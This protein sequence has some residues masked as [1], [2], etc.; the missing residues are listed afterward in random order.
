MAREQAPAQEG[1]RVTIRLTFK[2]VKDEDTLAI[3]QK[4]RQLREE[5]DGELEVSQL[6][7]RQFPPGA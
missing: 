2:R 5:L 6:E 1:Q 4:A 7:E 3:V